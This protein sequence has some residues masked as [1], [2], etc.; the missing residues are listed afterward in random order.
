M[1]DVEGGARAHVRAPSARVCVWHG[2]QIGNSFAAN[3]T[4]L[5]SPNAGNGSAIYVQPQVR[6]SS[7]M[8]AFLKHAWSRA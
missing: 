8:S 3:G 5:P 7:L 6:W 1:H 4:L 2:P